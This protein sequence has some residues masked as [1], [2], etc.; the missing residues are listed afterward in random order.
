M[1]TTASSRQPVYGTNPFSFA[2]PVE[3]APPLVIDQASSATAF[4]NVRDAASRGASIP[5][6]WAL[7]ASGEPTTDARAA[8]TGMLLAFGGGRGANMA[9]MV[10]VLAAGATGANWSLDAP[11][12][13]DGNASPGVG[14]FIIAIA[15]RALAP[16]LPRRLA[17]QVQ[18][19]QR[20]GI[21]VPGRG[22]APDGIEIP[23]ALLARLQRY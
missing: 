19:L 13:Q 17:A 23:Q 6:A 11:S 8:L 4:V 12:F 3:N 14:L 20:K 22:N 18:R 9:L 1:V 16:D 2:A 5:E 10:E 7:D 21:Y 15:P